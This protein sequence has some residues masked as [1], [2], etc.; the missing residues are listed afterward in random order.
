[1][2]GETQWQWFEQELLASTAAFNVIV[3]GVQ[4]LPADRF[5]VAEC[6]ARF[7]HERERLLRTILKSH[8]KGV[9]LLRC[10][11]L[12]RR[13]LPEAMQTYDVLTMRFQ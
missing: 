6:W 13:S 8:A 2:L 12:Q 1:M 5:A 4:I 11:S 7:P 9:I 3:S 10:V